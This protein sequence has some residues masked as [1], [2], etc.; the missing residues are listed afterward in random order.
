MVL[1]YIAAILVVGRL[2]AAAALGVP[3][4]SLWI[5]TAIIYFIPT[6]LIVAEL[7]TGWP[8]EGG[9]YIWTKQAM[10]NFSGFICGWFYWANNLVWYPMMLFGLVAILSKIYCPGVTL[11]TT[12]IAIISLAVLWFITITNV[13]GLNIGKWVPNIGTISKFLFIAILITLCFGFS[14]VHGLAN[15]F[16]PQNWIPT[17]EMTWSYVAVFAYAYAGHEGLSSLGDECEDPERNIP[18]A[19]LLSAIIIA[20]VYMLSSFAILAVNPTSNILFGEY[21]AINYVLELYGIRSLI[22]LVGILLILTDMGGIA[23][24]IIIPSRVLFSTGLNKQLPEVFSH[25]NSR[26][27]TPDY[28]LIIQ[29][30]ISSVLIVGYYNPS[31]EILFWTLFATASILYFISAIFLYIDVIILRIKRSEVPRRFHIPGGLLGTIVVSLPPLILSLVT[32]ALCFLP[33]PEAEPLSYE[34]MVAGGTLIFVLSA[35]I[36]YVV[37]SK[38]L[39]K[40]TIEKKLILN[41]TAN[42]SSF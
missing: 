15:D 38:R 36:I 7:G 10:G 25:I 16:A 5:I 4:L 8:G 18:R 28:A 12:I 14:L 20:L 9:I 29:A 11:D 22:Y 41:T 37:M 34:I 1:F 26:F 24:W 30:V 6:A 19:I 35:I 31:L 40:E 2:S 3:S 39:R 23:S 32:M 17:L 21:D 13:L 27:K 33:P 42:I